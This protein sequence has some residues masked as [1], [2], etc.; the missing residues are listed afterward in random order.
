MGPGL[1]G[2]IIAGQIGRG[3]T[4]MGSNRGMLYYYGGD[5]EGWSGA[6]C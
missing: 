3:R 4:T 2:E 1:K 5:L 6:Q